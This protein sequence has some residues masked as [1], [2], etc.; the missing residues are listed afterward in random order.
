M[1][2]RWEQV[3]PALAARAAAR[4]HAESSERD[5]EQA[6]L[7]MGW[8]V[9]SLCIA[10]LVISL[11]LNALLHLTGAAATL[12]FSL[13]PFAL[14][15]LIAVPEA[16]RV[17]SGPSPHARAVRPR[18]PRGPLT[19]EV[20]RRYFREAAETRAE[21]LYAETLI[22]LADAGDSISEQAGRDLLAQCDLLLA[23]GRRIE[24][25]RRR[26]R[27][28]LE[29]GAA[30]KDVEAEFAVLSRRRDG[31]ADPVVRASLEES[32]DL[33]ARRRDNLVVLESLLARQEAQ[34]ETIHQALLLAQ[35]ALV[36]QEAA[37]VALEAPSIAGLSTAVARITSES[38]AMEEAAREIVRLS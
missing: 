21:V 11:Y 30:L 35:A 18:V 4:W 22:L 2:L 10:V 24:R 16:A 19:A 31:E 26:V 12:A 17:G 9:F 34:E 15:A 25:S 23:A 38:R 28:L 37:A 36:R 8:S 7:H 27:S 32:M 14:V 1:Q 29:H 20:V 13:V 5:A 3:E 33:C 6:R